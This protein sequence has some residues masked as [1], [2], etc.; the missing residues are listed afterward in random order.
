MSQICVV[1]EKLQVVYHTLVKPTNEIKKYL[2]RFSGI[3]ADMLVDV[4]TR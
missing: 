1:D 2:T 4:D 3:T